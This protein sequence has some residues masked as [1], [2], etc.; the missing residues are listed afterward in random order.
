MPHLPYAVLEDRLLAL[1]PAPKDEGRVALVVARPDTD[2]RRTPDRARLSREAG[3]E[4]DRWSKRPALKADNQVTLMR[5]DVARLI[6]DGQELSLFGD[7]LLV[8]LDLSLENLPAGTRLRIGT[9]LCE[10]TPL[11]HT[12][13]GKFAARFGQD[14]RDVTNA[15]AFVPWRLRGIHVR[16]VEDGEVSPGDPVRVVERGV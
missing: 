12:G 1:P 6:A 16:V 3:L 15:P 8:E 14:A 10:V 13:C 9:A 5:A 7:N 2:L 11:P 4:G